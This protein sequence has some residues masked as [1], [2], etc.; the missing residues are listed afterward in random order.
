MELFVGVLE[1]NTVSDFSQFTRLGS[2]EISRADIY[3]SRRN[4]ANFCLYYKEYTTVESVI[5]FTC[6]Y[7]KF[8]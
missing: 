3:P 7:F 2:F 1:T 6:Q 5:Q 8:G 4:R